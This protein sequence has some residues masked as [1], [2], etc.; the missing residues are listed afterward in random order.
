MENLLDSRKEIFARLDDI[1]ARIEKAAAAAGRRREEVGLMAVTK[2]V[3]PEKVNF[4]IEYGVKLLGE[5]R[6]QEL[7]AKYDAYHRDNV[8][9]HF[10][11]ALQT[12]K[13]RS[14]IDKVSLI[15][16]VDS[17]RL[18]QEINR[19]AQSRLNRP[20][21]ILIEVNI[22]GEQSKAGVDAALALELVQQAAALPFLRVRGLMCIPPICDSVAEQ[23]R[24]FEKMHRLF[25]DIGDK[26]LDNVNMDFLSMGMSG[27]FEAAIRH[28]SNL[29]RIGSSMF[30]NRIYKG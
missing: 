24:Y 20:M 22:G 10:I 8:Q 30:G 9:I 3:E 17:L 14:I 19:L 25:V 7:C 23:E 26:K 12:N 15:Q 16:S 11:G 18:A 1:N 2:T 27:D 6:A 5:N 28:G 29:V 13:V 4:A 21:D